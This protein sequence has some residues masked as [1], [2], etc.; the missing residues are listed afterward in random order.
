[1]SMWNFNPRTP[2]GMRLA[3]SIA[4]IIS[5]YVFQS[6]HPLRD[7]TFCSYC[8]V[9]VFD[10]FNPRTPYGMRR[11]IQLLYNCMDEISI[12]AP[13]T[14]CDFLSY[15]SSTIPLA[16][17]IHAPLTGCDFISVLT[18]GMRY[19]FQS[20]HPL[21]DATKWNWTTSSALRFQS[22]HPLRD[23]TSM[24]MYQGHM[25]Q[26]FNPR[27]PYGMRHDAPEK[28]DI[29]SWFQSTHPLRDATQAEGVLILQGDISIHA[30]LTGCD[31][32]RCISSS[33][34]ISDFNPRTPYGMRPLS[35]AF[36]MTSLSFQST[37]PLR[38]ATLFIFNSSDFLTNFNPRTPYGM[39]LFD[40]CFHNFFRIISI[41][42][43]LTGCDVV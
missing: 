15:T 19:I 38:D 3:S 23:A 33:I 7:A 43:P 11:L 16:I 29:R 12:H 13:L 28:V 8:W 21:R 10:Y 27:T 36:V 20:T 1:M 39:R 17:S 37:H 42:A 22:T 9:L 2:Y 25:N 41:H 6:T 14:G 18:T 30:P 40:A 5:L 34:V 26:N 32:L 24:L 31:I 4:S 35:E